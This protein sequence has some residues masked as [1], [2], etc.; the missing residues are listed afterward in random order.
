MG[1]K[2][3]LTT[4]TSERWYALFLSDREAFLCTDSTLSKVKRTF[5]GAPG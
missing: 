2:V 3:P 5:G 4:K 1:A